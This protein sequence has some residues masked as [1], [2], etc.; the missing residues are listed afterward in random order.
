MISIDRHRPRAGLLRFIR[1]QGKHACLGFVLCISFVVRSHPAE[2]PARQE[3]ATSVP[4][5]SPTSAPVPTA[6]MPAYLDQVVDPGEYRVGPGDKILINVW[7]E[8]PEQF[9][10]TITPEAT[11]I[12]P[13]VCEIDVKGMTLKGLKEAIFTQLREFFPRARVSATLTEVR[14]FR[15][16]VTGAVEKPGLRVVTANTRASEVLET[17]GLKEDGSWRQIR[18]ERRDTTIIVD[19][20]AF[21]RLGLREAN[22]YL[23]EG[24][25]LVVAPRDPR[26]GT[27]EVSG[28]VNLPGRFGY[29]PGDLVGDLL[30]LAYGLSADADT[31]RLEL[32]RFAPGD[33][34][35]HRVEWP[36]GTTYGQ[37][38]QIMLLPDDR[39]LV[40]SLEE[41]RPKRSVV[42]TGEVVRPGRYVFRGDSISLRA[43]I[44]S[45]GGFTPWAD[46]SHSLI[47]RSIIP[48][49]SQEQRTRL[50]MIPPELRAQSE[51]DWLLA[52]ALS[53]P[54]RVATDFTRLFTMGDES[55]NVPLVD[56]D[57]VLVPRATE[58]V[59]VIGRV[60]QPGFV[61]F[62]PGAGLPHYLDRAGG[63][64]W[65]A[66]RGGTFLV[67]GA[68]GAAVKKRR[69]SE[70]SAGDTI[71]IPTRRGRKW[72]AAFRETMT[73]VSS[74]AT[75]Y[76]VVDQATK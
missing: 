50:G 3:R 63:Y 45:A 21:E 66:D 6:E 44:D 70:I 34:E 55:Y 23:A 60:V 9:P 74:L 42:V 71:V 41:Y 18:L 39:L 29:S 69:I 32:W 31:M 2:V 62:E 11:L 10:V 46:L 26:W 16:T 7:G 22:P 68:T 37:W 57:E 67:K 48:V 36:A 40:R 20:G 27:V 49:W 43:V 19:L 72:W 52:D 76:L 58:S 65:Q 59:N 25:I 33:N 61:P 12:I 5:P 8:R 15:V 35:V 30:E 47:V 56:R 1:A 64:S 14:R 13:G 54:G 73:V 24:D 17:A 28:S 51:T 53:V 38:R 75:V 4:V